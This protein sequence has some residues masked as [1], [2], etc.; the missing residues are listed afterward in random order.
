MCSHASPRR[1]ESLSAFLPTCV[2]RL[3]QVP[4]DRNGGEI[5]PPTQ[6]VPRAWTDRVPTARATTG[7]PILTPSQPA[8]R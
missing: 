8:R 5:T 4:P 2:N 1:L 6:S 3:T 7:T